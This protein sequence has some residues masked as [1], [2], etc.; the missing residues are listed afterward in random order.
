MAPPIVVH[1]QPPLPEDKRLLHTSESVLAEARSRFP[2]MGTPIP[3][4]RRL[5]T[6]LPLA[7]TGGA[8]LFNCIL[9]RPTVEWM[10]LDGQWLCGAESMKEA[11]SRE[12][13]LLRTVKPHLNVVGFLGVVDDMGLLIEKIDGFSLDTRLYNRS[14]IS[15]HL[16]TQWVNQIIEGLCHIHSFLLGHGD[17]SLGNILVTTENRI[18]II[19]F[20]NSSRNGERV[21]PG[22]VPFEAPEVRKSNMV[23]PILADAYAFGVLVLFID[24]I[25][26]RETIEIKVG[27]AIHFSALVQRYVRPVQ[28]RTRVH[29]SHRMPDA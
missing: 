25:L 24:A 2:I 14:T 22:T 15:L 5:H 16:K 19:D 8:V 3:P 6:M 10:F 20:G 17:I 13:R 27:S 26:P 28:T 7:T 21:F 18:K 4:D 29:L 11:F 1:Q 9:K 12:L 23:D